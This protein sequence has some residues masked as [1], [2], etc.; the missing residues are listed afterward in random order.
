[1]TCGGTDPAE[2]DSDRGVNKVIWGKL[3]LVGSIL[4]DS[5]CAEE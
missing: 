2:G 4:S 1:M 3:Q 5:E